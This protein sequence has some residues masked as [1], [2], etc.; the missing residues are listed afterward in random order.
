[1]REVLQILQMAGFLI[2]LLLAS[3]ITLGALI[4]ILGWITDK[5]TR[6]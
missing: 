2:I 3:V 6:K 4:E 1:M 5:F